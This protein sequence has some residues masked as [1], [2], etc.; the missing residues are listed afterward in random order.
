MNGPHYSES[1]LKQLVAS[2]DQAA[3]RVLFDLYHKKIFSLGMHLTHSDVM[4]E[5][6]VQDVF[7]KLWE[8][9]T[10]LANIDFLNSWIRTVS[11]NIA[12]NYLRR[13]T[14]EKLVLSEIA[15]AAPAENVDTGSNME[16]AQLLEQAIAQLP[17]QQR[18]VFI[19]FRKEG[20][21]GEEISKEMNLSIHS[22][23]T[24][25]KLS[26]QSV[27]EFLETHIELSVIVAIALYL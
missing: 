24:Y 16:L 4:A 9:R 6:L 26:T 19:L 18:R 15:T 11:K 14:L 8:K 21:S 23:R 17:P 20:L 22:V 13:I 25:I 27:K 1:E 7:I 5:E 12:S 3:F 10:E 2:G